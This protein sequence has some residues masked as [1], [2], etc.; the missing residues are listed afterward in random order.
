VVL[1][2][3]GL[4]LGSAAACRRGVPVIDTNPRPSTVDGTISGRVT[5]MADSTR[6]GGRRVEAI[7][8][9]TG[10]KVSVSTSPMG[11]FSLKVPPGKYRLVVELRNGESLARGPGTIEI[12]ESDLDHDI[13]LVVT[14]AVS[15][16]RQSDLMRRSDGLGSPI[17]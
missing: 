4:T 5:G 7:E 13:E 11:A 3:G 17:A 14:A 9:A 12:N 2:S 15:R 16:P 6:L 10:R 8:L 1:F